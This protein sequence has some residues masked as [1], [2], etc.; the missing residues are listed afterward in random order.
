MIGDDRFDVVHDIQFADVRKV[1]VQYLHHGMNKLENRQLILVEQGIKA[2]VAV[3]R[4]V[5]GTSSSSTPTRK[6][7]EAYLR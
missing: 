3:S 4:R 5:V 2:E 6:K 1:L 7:S